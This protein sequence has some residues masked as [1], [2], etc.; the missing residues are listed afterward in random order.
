MCEC[1]YGIF[2]AQRESFFFFPKFE[3]ADATFAFLPQFFGLCR[4]FVKLNKMNCF[5]KKV[6]L[7]TS[8]FLY[9]S[10][11]IGSFIK[12]FAVTDIFTSDKYGI[13]TPSKSILTSNFKLKIFL[14]Y[15][16]FHQS[17]VLKSHLS[18]SKLLYLE[19]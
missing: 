14:S 15:F 1:N 11:S 3:I 12:N 7:C 8:F 17:V 5:K 19:D 13:E 18:T 9:H 10:W 16:D 2:L 4:F 6:K